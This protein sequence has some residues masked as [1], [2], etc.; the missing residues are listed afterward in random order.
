MKYHA[1]ILLIA[2]L[3]G[4]YRVCRLKVDGPEEVPDPED[5]S[6]FTSV[7]V[8]VE[9]DRG[10]GA[11]FSLLFIHFFSLLLTFYSVYA[12]PLTSTVHNII[13]KAGHLVIVRCPYE[14][15]NRFCT[16]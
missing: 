4:I 1:L 11:H 7:G 13:N 14:H 8:Q 10:W 2:W 3:L 6:K 16:L 15:W 5:P 9:D 12:W